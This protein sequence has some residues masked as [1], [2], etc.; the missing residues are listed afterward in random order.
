MHNCMTVQ[1]SPMAS[2]YQMIIQ[3]LLIAG[4]ITAERVN[5]ECWIPVTCDGQPTW[6]KQLPSSP[7]CLTDEMWKNKVKD[8]E[9]QIAALFESISQM[10]KK[11]ESIKVTTSISRDDGSSTLVPDTTNVPITNEDYEQTTFEHHGEVHAATTKIET[12]E[13]ATTVQKIDAFE[14]LTTSENCGVVYKG[15]CFQL[16]VNEKTGINF[17]DAQSNCNETGASLANIYDLAHY[18]LLQSYARPMV[19]STI[20]GISP[21]TGMTYQN[22]TILLTTGKN[23]SLPW[24]SNFPA[25]D[26][27]KTNVVMMIRKTE[28]MDK[29]MMN[30]ESFDN[31]L[32]F[33]CET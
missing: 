20:S 4:V 11:L 25:S 2:Y 32:S 33:I 31:T 14:V 23:V 12:T 22:D 18:N 17:R 27:A 21:W 6:V 16:F 30:I 8:L 29:G 15:K 5:D 3:L 24:F 26:E 1:I 19:P 9:D 7:S 10:E 28:Q 13:K